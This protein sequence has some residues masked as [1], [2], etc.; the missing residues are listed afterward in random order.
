VSRDLFKLLLLLTSL[1]GVDEQHEKLLAAKKGSHI[2]SS[3]MRSAQK[4]LVYTVHVEY[5]HGR[6]C[7]VWLCQL[8]RATDPTINSKQYTENVTPAFCNGFQRLISRSSSAAA[9]C[10]FEHDV[11]FDCS[12]GS[13]A[14]GS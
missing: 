1:N 12:A 7:L 3:L 14:H 13:N 6:R 8:C 2:S 11:S 9:A 5:A 10:L 4:R